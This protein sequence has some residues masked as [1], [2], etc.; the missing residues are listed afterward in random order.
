MNDD[1]ISASLPSQSSLPPKGLHSLG[2]SSHKP[3]PVTLQLG[4][5]TAALARTHYHRAVE[6]LFAL[7]GGGR[8]RLEWLSPDASKHNQTTLDHDHCCLILPG[9]RHAVFGPPDGH[10][11]SALVDKSCVPDFLMAE[12]D[13]IIRENL[14]RL[15]SVEPLVSQLTGEFRR[16]VL[17]SAHSPFAH[18]VGTALVFK[19]LAALSKV[20][21][22]PAHLRGYGLSE[23]DQLRL[24]EY[25]A[26]NMGG[27]IGVAALA[28][29]LAMS[30]PHFNRRFRVSFGM[31]P[32]QYV[33]KLR[34]DRALALLRNGDC[35]VADAAYQV[36]FFDQSHLDRHC[37]KLYQVPPGMLARAQP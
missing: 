1:E 26:S 14:R 11:V 31:S 15:S 16:A 37:R 25:V 33:I 24:H 30:V 29:H 27:K 23:T 19:I 9:V 18:S 3:Y 34:V 22:Q 13:G 32:L 5:P 6:I 36:G 21:R 8:G 17:A 20:R 12:P 28:K 7:N 4:L 10:S 35:R 2:A